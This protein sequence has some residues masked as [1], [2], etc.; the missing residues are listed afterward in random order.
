MTATLTE[1]I[2]GRTLIEPAFFARLSR[3]V[4]SAYDL[5]PELAAAIA[6][7]TLAFLATAAQKPAGTGPLSP[8]LTV[9]RGVHCF[10]EY[11]A[12]YDRFFRVHGW[13]KVHHHPRDDPS[14]EYED[15]GVV[16]PRTVAAMREAGYTV[17]AD[18]WMTPRVDCSDDSDGL[19]G[20]PVPCGDHP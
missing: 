10:L 3:R 19:P 12:Q 11:T 2:A 9:D 16:I 4:A 13:P 18:L 1:A 14:K 17:L 6:D 20:D 7:Q 8:S 5:A 15:A